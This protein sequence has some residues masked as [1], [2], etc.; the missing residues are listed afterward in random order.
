LNKIEKILEKSSQP[1]YYG[2]DF[3]LTLR[4]LQLSAINK[5]MQRNIA[6]KYKYSFGLVEYLIELAYRNLD[7]CQQMLR[8]AVK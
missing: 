3:Q 7:Y 5:L 1:S 2:A 8:E 4:E 6:K